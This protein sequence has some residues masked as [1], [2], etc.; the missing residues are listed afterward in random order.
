[1][2]V[3]SSVRKKK[4]SE[5]LAYKWITC[6]KPDSWQWSFVW[7]ETVKQPVEEYS[8]TDLFFYTKNILFQCFYANAASFFCKFGI[9]YWILKFY[10]SLWTS[11]TKMF[12]MIYKLV[13]IIQRH[14]LTIC[15]SEIYESKVIYKSMINICS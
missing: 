15:L 8:S 4:K 11:L 12:Y 1:M 14:N 13:S 2:K 3:N 10:P 7:S 5:V 9:T 6:T